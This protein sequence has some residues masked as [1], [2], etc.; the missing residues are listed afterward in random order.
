MGTFKV[1][2][3]VLVLDA[4]PLI[5]QTP[6]Y[7]LA[8]RLVTLPDV[9]SEVRDE[10]AREALRRLPIPIELLH[11]SEEAVHAVT[12]F[13]KKTGDFASLS[14]TDLRVLALTW[15]LAKEHDGVEHIRTEIP[16]VLLQ[17][18]RL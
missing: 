7:H 11:P 1:K 18:I 8:E 2:T 4:A 17:F 13:A 15:K 3:R 14:A 6:L 16:V 5:K 12:R 9:L 10:Q